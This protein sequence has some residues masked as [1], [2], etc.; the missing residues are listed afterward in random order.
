MILR[1]ILGIV[2]GL[3]WGFI[4]G[5]PL[6][7]RLAQAAEPASQAEL[8]PQPAPIATLR[9]TVR[10]D[11]PLIRLGDLFGNIGDKGGVAVAYAP[12]PGRRQT[13]DAQWLALVARSHRIRWGATSQYDRAVIERASQVISAAE[14]ESEIRLALSEAVRS[15]DFEVDFAG[16]LQ[17]VHIATSA[18]PTVLVRD[19]HFDDATGRFSATLLVS[20]NSDQSTRTQVAGRI[21]ELMEVPVLVRHLNGGDVIREGTFELALRRRDEIRR[22]TVVDPAGLL[23][24][25]ATRSLQAGRMVQTREVREQVLVTRRK[26]VTLVYQSAI[27]TLTARGVALDDGARGDTVRVRNQ[28]SDR[29]IEGV[30]TGPD[31]VSVQAT[32]TQFVSTSN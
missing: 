6:G 30:V 22:G 25:Q 26:A 8:A 9:G 10:V 20:P 14:I 27:M 21:H 23:G 4:G 24:M 12:A 32:A 29:V 17:D 15:P 11:D 16:R 7:Y 31:T 13:F 2:I 18:D 5:A 1:L 3:V 28:R 19:M